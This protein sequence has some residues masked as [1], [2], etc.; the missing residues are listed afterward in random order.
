MDMCCTSADKVDPLKLRIVIVLILVFFAVLCLPKSSI[1]GLKKMKQHKGDVVL[2]N[3]GDRNT[4]EIKKMEFG[5]LHLKSDLVADTLKLD[6]QEVSHVESMARYEFETE[7]KD[8]YVGT[9]EKTP[10]DEL[11]GSLTVVLDN[12]SK[13]E[14]KIIQIISIREMGRNFFAR[15]NLSLDAGASF[16]SANS[17]KQTSFNLTASYR[18]PKY[19]TTLEAHS[20]FSGE[21]GIENTERHEVQL[22]ATRY[23]AR[24]WD[25]ILL[26]AFLHDNQQELDLRTTLG[27]GILRSLYESNRTRFFTVGGVVYTNENYFPEAQLDRN[28]IEALG[29]LGFQTYRFRGSS[30]NTLVSTYVSLSDPGRVRVDTNF[31]WKWDIVSDLYFKVSFQDNYDNRPPETGITH[32]LNV[33]STVGWSF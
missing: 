5:V 16:T 23:L 9:I 11:P 10:E 30:F 13:V 20:Q 32:N 28:N 31:N 24:K 21:P 8:V 3:N 2:M 26:S 1:A 12:G 25:A 15:I 7:T 6:W 17:R 18:K 22:A 29:A 19:T 27:G 33:T 4:G 14:L